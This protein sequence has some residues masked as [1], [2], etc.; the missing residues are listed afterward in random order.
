MAGDRRLA[1]RLGVRVLA[2]WVTALALVACAPIGAGILAH[3]AW[4]LFLAGW[5]A[6]E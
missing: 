6:V 2:G 5:R 4:S 1:G 3:A